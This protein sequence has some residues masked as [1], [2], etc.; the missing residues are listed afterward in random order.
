MVTRNIKLSNITVRPK[1]NK[2]LFLVLLVPLLFVAYPLFSTP[3]IPVGNGDLPYIEIS[4]YSFKK[5]W[6]WNEFGSYHGLETLPRYPIIAAFQIVNIS[7]DVS[8]KLLII[9]GFAIASFSFY[10]SCLKIFK[11]RLDIES[12]KFKIAAILGS[13][14]YA[15]NVW[16]FHR[17]GHWYF[18]LGFAILPLFLV[19]VIFAF[20]NP[21]RW[22]YVL[23][24]VL[25]WSVASSTPH[26]AVFF[27]LIFVALAILFTFQNVRR[28]RFKIKSI[29]LKPI[30]VTIIVYVMVNLY[31][32][33]PY[34][35][36]A[37][38]ESFL[39]SAVVTEEITRELSRESDLLSVLRL[40][41][42]TFNM[43]II[44]VVPDQASSLFPVWSIVSLVP[45]ILAFSSV[46]FLRNRNKGLD[47]IILL[48]CA[49]AIIGILLTMGSNAPF[50]LYSALL[51]QTPLTAYLQI[52]FREPDKWGFLVSLAFSFLIVISCF[53]ILDSLKSRIY[54]R[55]NIRILASICFVSFIFFSFVIYVYPAY[56]DSM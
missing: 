32:I 33:Y 45:P 14:F 55:P 13:L 46:L 2:Y 30:S 22:K 5:F 48:F 53:K 47:K 24:S 21:G 41:E 44:D 29:L 17:I 56:R 54:K 39:W 27:A 7:P 51:F 50:G 34:L 6:T 52:I 16:S 1:F 38:S 43:G 8:S 37:S 26:M 15:Y 28:K 42:G 9:G 18:W 12:I 31:W 10:V 11:N 49:L 23:A 35:V 4:L 19:S 25:L 20:R 36:S 40:I 3:G